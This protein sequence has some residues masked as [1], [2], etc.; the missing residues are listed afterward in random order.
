MCVLCVC[1]VC[2][3]ARVTCMSC[4]HAVR[5]VASLTQGG[6]YYSQF[7]SLYSVTQIVAELIKQ[8]RE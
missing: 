3:C 1:A 2:A 6:Q 4:V 5:R 7:G 8:R